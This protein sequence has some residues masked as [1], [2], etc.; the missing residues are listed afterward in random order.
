MTETFAG[1]GWD[2]SARQAKIVAEAQYVGGVNLMCQHLLP[3]SERGQRK[4][5]YPAH[6]SWVN[7]WVRYGFRPFND[8]F[9]RLGYLLGESQELVS[10]GVFCPIRSL[11]FDYQR[12]EYAHNYPI[13]DHYNQTLRMLS[14]MQIPYHIVDET[15]LSKHGSVQNGCLIVGQCQYNTLIFPK[16]YTMDRE[17]TDLLAEYLRQGGKVLFLDEK[18]SY[19]EGTPWVCPWESNVSLTD[20]RR[21]QS[22]TVSDTETTVRSTLRQIGDQQFLYA[23]NCD[24]HQT[25]T[26]E[27]T[28]NFSGFVALDLETGKRSPMGTRLHFTPGQSYV[29]FLTNERPP[30]EAPSKPMTLQGPFRIQECSDNYLTLD[31]VYYAPD[32]HTFLGPYSCMGLFQDLLLRR[33][34]GEI[35]LQYR[36]DVAALPQRLY[37]LAEDMNTYECRVNGHE[38]CFDGTSEF[39]SQLY[40]AN[41]APLVQLG[42]NRVEFRI[43]FYQTQNVYDVLFGDATESLRNCLVY[44]TTVEA[45]YLQGD[46]GVYAKDGFR[47]GA[48]ANVYLADAFYLGRRQATVTDPI[49]DGY[50]FFAGAM[51][52]ETTFTVEAVEKMRLD[53]PGGYARCSVQIN[54]KTVEMSYF[55]QSAEIGDYIKVGEN[56]AQI[57]LYSGNRNLLGPH[58][59][60]QEEPHYVA[61]RTFEL[62]GSWKDGKS[63]QERSSYSFVRFGL[64]STQE[65]NHGFHI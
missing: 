50:P 13:N 23:V 43:R 33:F 34:D 16:T 52:L 1:C 4:R 41:I 20:I 62:P 26:L 35:W 14:A 37:L 61:P 42:E 55:A 48:Q 64:F 8:Y 25:A 46:F 27:F 7:P 45:C 31:Q 54:G 58:H 3:Y 40:R 56:V 32:G 10:V 9:A 63:E 49:L 29:L 65:E 18:P 47:K 24:L 28:G 36:F 6:F 5:D 22:Y 38:V 60:I 44:N 51:V 53:L 59:N 21:A 11:Y 39:E 12:T 30:V 57:T 17:T 19:M 15:I 2:L